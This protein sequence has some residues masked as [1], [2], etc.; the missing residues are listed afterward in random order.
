MTVGDDAA[1]Q[2]WR[3]WADVMDRD[4]A[5]FYR[6]GRGPGTDFRTATT[7]APDVLADAVRALF[8]RLP[9]AASR[10]VVEVGAGNGALL[11][12]L[13][14]RLPARV[15]LAG[16]ERRSRPAGLPERVAWL[17]VAPPGIRGLL[18]AIE[19]LDTVPVDV[20]RDGRVLLVDPAGRERS[21]PSPSAIDM[22]WLARWWPTGDRTEVGRRRDAA[23]TRALGHLDAGVAVAVDYG[24]QR[25]DRPAGGSLTGYRHGRVVV[26]APGGDRDVTAGV[27]WDAVAAAAVA[28]RP[29][30]A[31]ENTVLTTQRALLHDLG[32]TADIPART[33]RA[34]A[35]AAALERTSRAGVLLDPSGLGGFGVLL[36]AVGVAAA[37][38]PG[39]RPGQPPES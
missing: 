21:G 10:D 16:V 8:D 2:G 36:H 7:A 6:L 18:L 11:A 23:W 3:T 1:A 22:A 39:R 13:A 31:G 33:R 26:P 15:R 20:V 17:P 28:H 27:A 19:W 32:I 12:A 4:L 24:H 30:L 35:F 29:M 14:T 38:L 25:N 9:P 5:G 34:G 37:L